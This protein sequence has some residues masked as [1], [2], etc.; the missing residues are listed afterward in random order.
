[1]LHGPDEAGPSAP[2]RQQ[3][4]FEQLLSHPDVLCWHLTLEHALQ[5]D[6]SRQ[7][8]QSAVALWPHPAQGGCKALPGLSGG[9]RLAPR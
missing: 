4:L 9:A 7:P 6:S 1:M 8:C 2:C 5:Q 3:W